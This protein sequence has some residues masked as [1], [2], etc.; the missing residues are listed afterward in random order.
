[1]V[2]ETFGTDDKPYFSWKS[3]FFSFSAG[4][5]PNFE[6]QFSPQS[7]IFIKTRLLTIH[8]SSRGSNEMAEKPIS[9]CLD[10]V[11]WRDFQQPEHLTVLRALTS[12]QLPP[13]TVSFI[14]KGVKQSPHT[15]RHT[16]THSEVRCSQG[17]KWQT[18]VVEKKKKKSIGP[19]IFLQS[20]CHYSPP[21]FSLLSPLSDAAWG[22]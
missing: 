11:I 22:L 6:L 10:P 4:H 21:P 3:C 19:H 8:W 2:D 7:K 13:R 14:M 9:F 17:D 20:P 5:M 18:S 15:A 12:M 1:M 16:N